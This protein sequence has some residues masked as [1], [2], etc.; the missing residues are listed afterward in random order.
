[1]PKN[2]RTIRIS[3]GVI[4]QHMAKKSFSLLFALALVA[5][6]AFGLALTRSLP[7]FLGLQDRI[8][9]NTHRTM[10]SI[11]V[12]IGGWR[13][14]SPGNIFTPAGRPLWN[15]TSYWL[16]HITYW[17]GPPLVTWTI[18]MLAFAIRSRLLTSQPGL[19]VG[20]AVAVALAVDLIRCL[21]Y[22]TANGM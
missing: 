16:R 20:L 14:K 6:T 15:R 12:S 10:T 22:A 18:V 4:M 11:G 19:V 7:K 9:M 3:M 2:G 17:I 13:V 8:E 21:Q 1:M 5:A